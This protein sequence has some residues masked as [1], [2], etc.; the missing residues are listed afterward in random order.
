MAKGCK[1]SSRSVTSN[2]VLV[3]IIPTA[4]RSVLSKGQKAFNKLIRHI[5]AR[6]AELAAWEGV[7]PCYG[8]KF[9]AE[10]LPQIEVADELQARFL[11]R[12]DWAM[13]LKGL[14]KI[15]RRTLR[16][17]IVELAG[18]LIAAGNDPELKALYNKYSDEDFDV[19]DA[20]S[21]RSLKS[22]LEM[23]TGL[24]LGDDVDW[25]S[26]E[27]VLR[28]V[29][30]QV[31]QQAQ[32]DEAREAGRK[33]TAKQIEKEEKKRAEEQEVSQS[34]REVYRKLASSLHPDRETDP[35]E[36]D[37]KTALMQRV[38]MA[39]SS[40]N[41]LQLLELQLELEHIDQAAINNLSEDRLKH[42]NKVLR[43]QLDELEM[44]IGHVRHDFMLR[45]DVPPFAL[46]SPDF[47]MRQ[48]EE[49][50]ERVRLTCRH[51]E[52]DIRVFTDVKQVKLW[53]KEQRLLDRFDQLDPFESPARGYD[54]YDDCPF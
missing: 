41:L 23:M 53:L 18:E 46:L 43:T 22:D 44:E 34:I 15:E 21:I 31:E 51:L 4:H 5:D 49:D 50:I 33:K 48:L 36:R 26:P 54:R 52:E 3:A 25:S 32:R 47:A 29:Y 39:Y 10:Y 24:D 45:F 27:D 20:A 38:N 13:G 14:S 12:M 35:Q 28:H 1:R 8:V 7:V 42:Y 9:N 30:A 11:H 2:D 6:R 19:E 37:R 16:G 17:H 40:R